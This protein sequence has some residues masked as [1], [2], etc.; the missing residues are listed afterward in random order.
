MNT[1]YETT[2]RTDN[3]LGL[4]DQEYK[5]IVAK[6]TTID[7]HGLCWMFDKPHPLDWPSYLD[8]PQAGTHPNF[9]FTNDKG[10]HRLGNLPAMHMVQY[11]HR[12]YVVAVTTTYAIDGEKHREFCPADTVVDHESRETVEEWWTN[13]KLTFRR[14]ELWDVDPYSE[15]RVIEDDFE[16][17]E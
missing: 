3:F 10:M 5:A 4:S 1:L 16:E 2:R 14:T 13:G 12:G 9:V 8:W 6:Y 15:G 11:D 17:D 7:D